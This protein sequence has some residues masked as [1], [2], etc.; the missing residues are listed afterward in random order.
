MLALIKSNP[1]CCKKNY[2]RTV[3][4]KVTIWLNS[5]LLNLSQLTISVTCVSEQYTYPICRFARS[6]QTAKEY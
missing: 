1:F 3:K 2:L 5:V 6:F 4:I